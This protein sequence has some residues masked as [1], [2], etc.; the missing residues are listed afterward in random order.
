[1]ISCIKLKENVPCEA[2]RIYRKSILFSKAIKYLEQNNYNSWL[3]LS[4]NY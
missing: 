2:G 4:A 3:I 1:M